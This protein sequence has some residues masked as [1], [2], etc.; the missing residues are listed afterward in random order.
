V[1][2]FDPLTWADPENLSELR[3]M[4]TPFTMPETGTITVHLVRR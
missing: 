2:S 4:A 1:A 3:K